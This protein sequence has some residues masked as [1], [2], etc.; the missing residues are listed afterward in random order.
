MVLWNQVHILVNV[1]E[2]NLDW[3]AIKESFASHKCQL[4]LVGCR[5]WNSHIAKYK[6]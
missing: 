3:I 1:K 6:D 4:Q 2:N 5:I